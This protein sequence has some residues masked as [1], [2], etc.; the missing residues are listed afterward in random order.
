MLSARKSPGRVKDRRSRAPARLELLCQRPPSP[1]ALLESGAFRRRE[2]A[3]LTLRR[4]VGIRCQTSAV[5]EGRRTGELDSSWVSAEEF[6]ADAAPCAKEAEQFTNSRQT[7]SVS[8]I[9]E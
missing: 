7:T 6:Q 3:A 5:V 1:H 9:A 4:L 2:P 8:L